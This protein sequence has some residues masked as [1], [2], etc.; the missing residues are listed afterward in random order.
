MMEVWSEEAISCGQVFL[1]CFL[2]AFVFIIMAILERNL[3]KRV[4]DIKVSLW[5]F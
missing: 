5:K 4:E 1:F 2:F 3:V